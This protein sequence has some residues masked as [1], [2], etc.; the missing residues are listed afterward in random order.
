MR[1]DDIDSVGNGGGLHFC[2]NEVWLKGELEL[3]GAATERTTAADL[4]CDNKS[5]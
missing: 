2:E 4:S 5:R 1:W 3:S